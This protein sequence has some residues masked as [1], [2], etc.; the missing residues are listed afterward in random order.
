MAASTTPALRSALLAWS[1]LT[2]P[3]TTSILPAQQDDW[4]EFRR[5]LLEHVAAAE[6]GFSSY[7]TSEARVVERDTVWSVR[8]EGCQL[9]ARARDGSRDYRC[10]AVPEVDLSQA[11][12]RS[13][14]DVMAG[15]VR[16]A[17]GTTWKFEEAVRDEGFIRRRLDATRADGVQVSLW[18]WEWRETPP[19]VELQVSTPAA[20][21][22]RQVAQEGVAPDSTPQ[23]SAPPPA[24]ART[25]FQENLLLVISD[26]EEDRFSFLAEDEGEVMDGDT[27]Y[28]ALSLPESE[29]CDVWG[30]DD[31]T[32][33]YACV[34]THSDSLPGV[35]R[36]YDSLA[37]EIREALGSTWTFREARNGDRTLTATRKDGAVV[38]LW[39]SNRPGDVNLELSV[40][41]P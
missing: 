29:W 6:T 16:Q 37:E 24:R 9:W 13:L 28:P 39:L 35:A 12:A 23:A 40:G 3:V 25:E 8:E 17:L 31:G 19:D 14:Y 38:E 2:A 7:A 15:Q 18:I 10:E 11:A 20:A 27:V 4:A 41:A 22:P 1:L 30:Y 5:I 33:E 26:G 32:R 36:R 21:V 34:M